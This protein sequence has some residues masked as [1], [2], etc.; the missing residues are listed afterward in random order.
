MTR[1]N[2]ANVIQRLLGAVLALL[3]LEA[4]AHAYCRTTTCNPRDPSKN[5]TVDIGS[6]CV[7]S[8]VAIKWYTPCISFSV[9]SSNLRLDRVDFILDTV[10]RAF[11]AWWHEDKVECPRTGDRPQIT[12]R[13][14]WGAVLCGHV[15]YNSAQGNANVITFRD[16]WPYFQAGDE[17]ARTTVTYLVQTGEIV[18]AD[19]EVNNEI[20]FSTSDEIPALAFDLQSVLTHEAGHFLG[21]AHSTLRPETVMLTEYDPGSNY[22]TLRADDV[23]AVCDVYGAPDPSAVC[24]FAPV[25]GFSA[26]CAFDPGSGGWCAAEPERLPGRGAGLLLFVGM[27][28][29]VISLRRRWRPL[30][31]PRTGRARQNHEGRED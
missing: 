29:G 8:G 2:G 1:V 30:R 27:L 5:C 18:D 12:V 14:E 25:N 19:I 20:E 6:G 23:N 26:E 13:H 15:E 11:E 17:L 21:I 10:N 16:E 9:D 3:V 31:V 28:A 22:R 7:T 24:D 4:P